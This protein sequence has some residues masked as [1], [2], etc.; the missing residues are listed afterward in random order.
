MLD[1][2]ICP[3]LQPLE[4]CQVVLVNNNYSNH[5]HRL[6]QRSGMV[7]S[8]REDWVYPRFLGK[9]EVFFYPNLS[10]L[11]CHWDNPS[12]ETNLVN[13]I[14]EQIRRGNKKS[15]EAEHEP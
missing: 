8:N 3:W 6:G 10:L 4:M 14:K 2:Q 15:N 13:K 12:A 1:I 7:Y 9:A 5:H 11:Q